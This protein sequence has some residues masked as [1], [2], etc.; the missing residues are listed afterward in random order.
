MPL[1]K[2]VGLGPGHIVLGGDPVGTHPPQQPLP[3]FGSCLL[4]PNGRPSQQ[5]LLF[6]YSWRQRVAI[7]YNG[8]PLFPVKIV[9]TPSNTWFP[10]VWA[11]LS[12]QPKRHLDRFSRFCTTH[13]RV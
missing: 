6:L 7:L 9:S 8:L 11:Y 13:R 10:W 3:T 1:G 4:W 12:P 2:E 5:L